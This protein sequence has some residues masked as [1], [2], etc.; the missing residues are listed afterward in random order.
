[1]AHK[2][3]DMQAS[4]DAQEAYWRRQLAGA[5]VLELP[6]DS[7]R[8]PVQS[9]TRERETLELDATFCAALTRFC[10]RE[11]V[12]LFTSLL[13][14]FVVLLHRYTEEDDIIVGSLAAVSQQDG[15]PLANPVALRIN[16]GGVPSVR[17]L[18]RRVA[19][20]MAETLANSHY[21]FEALV[22]AL[23]TERDVARAPIFQAMCLCSCTMS[24]APLSSELLEDAA[25]Y[26]MRCDIVLAAFEEAGAFRVSCE[27]DA[28]LFEA[29]SIQRMLG[30]FHL[31]LRGVV[32]TPEHSIARL[33]LVTEA[34]RHQLLGEWNETQTLSL[35][36]TCIHQL[37]E[38]QVER[39]PD[40]VA[41]ICEDSILTYRDLNRSANQLAHHLRGLGVRPEDRVGLCVERSLDVM[42][43]LLGILKAGGV[44]VP[45]DPVY[46][47]ERLAFMLA[48]AQAHVVVTHAKLVSRLDASYVGHI[49]RLDTDQA[50]IAAKSQE[51]TVQVEQVMLQ[52]EALLGSRH[53]KAGVR[54]QAHQCLPTD[55]H[56]SYTQGH[57]GVAA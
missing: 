30:H 54:G 4:W 45:L 34:E 39:T 10:G 14:A 2:G 53:N 28:D 1:M 18:C 19:H 57:C 5:P 50:V 23:H 32:A 46:P 6:L 33:P 13:T 15:E 3:A 17:E 49:V 42:V 8:P 56:P 12:T 40:A 48:D 26:M 11:H 7:P 37:F 51:V 20:T 31:L 24:G 36:D 29:A 25:P 21:P 41:V 52:Q 27:Y 35:P 9:F 44:Y 22:N 16:L 38:E 47:Q 43:G 55:I